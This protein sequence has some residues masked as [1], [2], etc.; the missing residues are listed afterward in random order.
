MHQWNILLC[1]YD[2][3]IVILRVGLLLKAERFTKIDYNASDRIL[4]LPLNTEFHAPQKPN[5]Y[6]VNS[7]KKFNF[8][9]DI[10]GHIR[11]ANYTTPL[12]PQTQKHCYV[13]KAHPHVCI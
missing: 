10:D 12:H 13:H 8:Q 4:S 3:I 1:I 5:K 6:A 9:S 2:S 7:L 11:G